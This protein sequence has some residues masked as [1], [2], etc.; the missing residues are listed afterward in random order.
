MNFWKTWDDTTLLAQIPYT[1][2]YAYSD[3]DQ[4]VHSHIAIN[5][6]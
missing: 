5:L 3:A 1:T 4:L 6:T 2:L